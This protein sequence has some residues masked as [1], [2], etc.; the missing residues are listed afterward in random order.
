MLAYYSEGDENNP[1]GTRD[2]LPPTFHTSSHN[3]NPDG[4]VHSDSGVNTGNPGRLL[5]GFED[6]P[7][8]D[9]SNPSDS[10]DWDLRDFVFSVEISSA[11]QTLANVVSDLEIIDDSVDLQSATVQIIQGHDADQL[12]LSDAIEVLSVSYG[13]TAGYDAASR[14]LHFSGDATA[15]Q[16]QEILSEIQVV[17][18]GALGN[19]PRQIDIRVTDIDGNTSAAASINL[20][21]DAS[22]DISEAPL[23]FDG[24]IEGDGNPFSTADAN[25]DINHNI[26]KLEEFLLQNDFNVNGH[27]SNKGILSNGTHEIIRGFEYAPLPENTSLL[28]HI[29]DE[30]LADKKI[31]DKDLHEDHL[32]SSEFLFSD[33]SHTEYNAYSII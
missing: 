27:R 32:V 24:S 19:D 25:T 15:A 20:T 8:I 14:T 33:A 10:V 7:A 18:M 4:L 22:N 6:R 28:S 2:E 23:V 3:L 11:A 30:M 16:Y 17:N 26:Y 1:G 31:G 5:I 12:I 21:I 13:I 9:P 29:T